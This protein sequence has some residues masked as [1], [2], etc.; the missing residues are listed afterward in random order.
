MALTHEQKIELMEQAYSE[1]YSG[2]ITDLWAQHDP[3]ESVDLNTPEPETMNASEMNTQSPQMPQDPTGKSTVNISPDSNINSQSLIQSYEASAPT[4]LPQ[5]EAV[6]SVLQDPS[7]YESGG[8]RIRDLIDLKLD[9]EGINPRSYIENYKKTYKTREMGGMREVL[10]EDIVQLTPDE[11]GGPAK[12]TDPLEF[13]KYYYTSEKHKERMEESGYTDE[14]ITDR[15][16]FLEGEGPMVTDKAP[17]TGGSKAY[18]EHNSIS[19]DPV[20]DSY[21][22]VLAHEISHL[23]TGYEG[24]NKTDQKEIIDRNAFIEKRG[25]VPEGY[26]EKEWSLEI[27]ADLDSIRYMLHQAGVYD[28]GQ[29]EFDFYDMTQTKELLKDSGIFKRM[30]KEYNENDFMWLMN[31]IAMTDPMGPEDNIHGDTAYAQG[32]GFLNKIKSHG[33]AGGGMLGLKNLNVGKG[34]KGNIGAGLGKFKAGLNKTFQ[35]RNLDL[36]LK[37]SFNKGQGFGASLG[38]R[39]RFQGGGVQKDKKEARLAT[40]VELEELRMMHMIPGEFDND[41]IGPQEGPPEFEYEKTDWQGDVRPLK[42]R[43]ED[44]INEWLDDPMNK[45]TKKAQEI[46]DEI[47]KEDTSFPLSPTG[48]RSIDQ[49]NPDALRHALSS[50]YTTQKVGPILAN[51]F[52]VGHELLRK[53]TPKEHKEDI[54]NNLIGS[55]VGSVPF[56]SIEGKEKIIKQLARK[57]WLYKGYEKPEQKQFGGFSNLGYKRN[58]PHKNRRFNII[59]SN[60]ITMEG[61]DRNILGIDNLGNKKI[62]RPGRNYKFPG[63]YVMETPIRTKNRKRRKK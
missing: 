2:F 31:N 13:A 23:S 61:V 8:Y 51:L 17:G 34:W 50:M 35:N 25:S 14:D 63:N 52:G 56:T 58:S 42:R 30:M 7:Q 41:F 45:G 27:K 3:E 4:E 48:S 54:L 9:L 36:N 29:E 16:K 12:S 44:K 40:P 24:L 46:A 59:P 57:G 21:D 60:R 5:G 37:G 26:T 15:S 19:M 22:N 6:S 47:A 10:P 55:M 39:K 43:A 20:V 38:L 18:P 33:T 53:N 32:G 1:G 28:A 49:L 11:Q 62:M